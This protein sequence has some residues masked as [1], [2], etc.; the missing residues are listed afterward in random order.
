MS[1]MMLPLDSGSGNHI[2][3]GY[4]PD[5]KVLRVEFANGSQ[6]D[7]QGVTSEIAANFWIAPSQGKYLAQVI[8]PVCPASKVEID[9]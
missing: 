9:Q 8:K 4:D 3:A 5:Q 6:Y 7:Y 1:F 2:S